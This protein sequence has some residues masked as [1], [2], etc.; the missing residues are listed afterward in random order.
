MTYD[1]RNEALR[2][3]VFYDRDRQKTVELRLYDEKRRK[4]APEDIIAFTNVADGRKISVRVRAVRVFSDFYE[5]YPFYD[6][7]AIG[8]REDEQAKPCDM[9]KYYSPEDISKYGVCAIELSGVK[10][11]GADK[12]ENQ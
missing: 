8:Y 6:K 4:I 12:G 5:L 1:S 3:A 9:E 2:R 10:R 11:C 7:A